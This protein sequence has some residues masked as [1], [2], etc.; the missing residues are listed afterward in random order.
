[1]RSEVLSWLPQLQHGWSRVVGL[2]FVRKVVVHFWLT[3]CSKS[4]D[5]FVEGPFPWLFPQFDGYLDL[6]M[7][8]L[9]G[10]ECITFI[11]LTS[12]SLTGLSLPKKLIYWI[13][14]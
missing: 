14:L 4:P 2:V 12:P 1:M 9:D 6:P 10:H 11:D 13:F 3:S 5:C 8:V 7:E